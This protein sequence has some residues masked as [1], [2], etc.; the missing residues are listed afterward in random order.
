MFTGK[1][2]ETS[3]QRANHGTNKL[4][5]LNLQR[6]TWPWQCNLLIHGPQLSH[7]AIFV[8]GATCTKPEVTNQRCPFSHTLTVC[9]TGSAIQGRWRPSTGSSGLSN[10]PYVKPKLMH[11]M[12]SR[13]Y[14]WQNT[15]CVINGHILTRA[16]KESTRLSSNPPGCEALQCIYTLVGQKEYVTGLVSWRFHVFGC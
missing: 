16:H 2:G 10:S 9:S 8:C 15:K 12:S 14:Y 1:N 4:P 5:A 6:Q 11:S 7:C 3:S 13:E